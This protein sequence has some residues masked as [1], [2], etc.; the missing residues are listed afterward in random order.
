MESNNIVLKYNLPVNVSAQSFFSPLVEKDYCRSSLG[1]NSTTIFHLS[2]D[3]L[4]YI[5]TN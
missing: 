1:L 5:S 4:E 3:I 2:D